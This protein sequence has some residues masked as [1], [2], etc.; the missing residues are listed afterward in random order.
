MTLLNLVG[1]HG[2]IWI[3][4]G[5]FRHPFKTN[6]PR[7]NL[8]RVIS[9]KPIYLMNKS[10]SLKAKTWNINLL[11]E[12]FMENWHISVS[13]GL[14]L[15]AATSG[16]AHSELGP[17]VATYGKL[18][19]MWEAVV[20]SSRWLPCRIRTSCY[21]SFQVFKWGLN[22]GCLCELYWHLHFVKYLKLKTKTKQTLCRPNAPHMWAWLSLCACGLQSLL[23]A[24]GI[25][26]LNT[27]DFNQLSLA[28]KLHNI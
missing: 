2:Q 1:E 6:W 10:D 11:N 13:P 5:M 18:E 22:S 15:F 21:Q 23:Y 8:L 14:G 9:T 16:R 3:S 25:C 27:R 20:S 24:L 28:S 7:I 12:Q 26:L 4:N 17:G 19:N